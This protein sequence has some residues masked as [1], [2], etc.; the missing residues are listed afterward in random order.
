MVEGGQE[1][2]GRRE[3]EE[4]GTGGVEG[5]GE[6]REAFGGRRGAKNLETEEEGEEKR[7]RGEGWLA[8]RV[9]EQEEVAVVDALQ[10]PTC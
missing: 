1:E 2:E 10:S 4:V 5:V 6:R 7:R 3:G 8:N 9:Q